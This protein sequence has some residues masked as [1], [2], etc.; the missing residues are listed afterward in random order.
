MTET[1]NKVY[2]LGVDDAASKMPMNDKLHVMTHTQY[3]HGPRSRP[4][5][6]PLAPA[7]CTAGTTNKST[8]KPSPISPTTNG[9]LPDG[10]V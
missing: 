4:L 9:K 8:A 5:T 6:L 10:K 3:K 1:M 2:L 7:S